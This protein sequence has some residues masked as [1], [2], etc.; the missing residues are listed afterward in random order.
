MKQ[1]ALM[2]LLLVWMPWTVGAEEKFDAKALERRL[3]LLKL[4]IRQ[5]QLQARHHQLQARALQI[6]SEMIQVALE[7]DRVQR[8]HA[9][10]EA[11]NRARKDPH[12]HAQHDGHKHAQQSTPKSNMGQA[13]KHLELG[14]ACEKRGDDKGALAEYSKAIEGAPSLPEPYLARGK[15]LR[16]FG[17]LELALKDYGQALELDPQN[18]KAWLA[19]GIV[20]ARTSQK[21]KALKALRRA[22]KL[23]PKKQKSRI[24]KLIVSLQ[25]GR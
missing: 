22:R 15:L 11:G 13:L 17:R 3:A 19:Y 5:H 9:R 12:D 10:L 23:A 4:E 6:E 24:D 8:A 25:Y 1:L 16:S 7:M 18:W 20:L 2:A 14:A 21:P